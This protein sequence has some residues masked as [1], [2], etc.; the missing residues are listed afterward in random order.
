MSLPG[1]GLN[2]EEESHQ[3]TGSIENHEVPKECEWRFEVAFGSYVQV[4]LVTGTAEIFGTELCPGQSYT[5]TGTKAAIFTWEGCTIQVS[6][7]ALQSD[8]I[9]EETPMVEYA[10]VHFALEALRDAAAQAGRD[11]P[12]VLL[13][14]PDNAGKT[15]LTK[16]LTGYA[17]RVGRQPIVVNVDPNE[18][19][20]SIPGTLSSAAFK[21]LIDV[22]EG[23]GSSP[24]SGPSANPVKLPLVYSYPLPSPSIQD[25]AHYRPVISKLALSVIGR[26]YED[27]A[28]RPSGLIVDTPSSLS[29]PSASTFSTLSHII[30]E[31]RISVLLILGSE[32]LSSDL[33]KRFHN[34]PTSATSPGETISVLKL[35]KS[36]GCVDRDDTFMKPLRAAQLRTYFYGN[37]KLSAGI[38]LSPHQLTIP[39]SNLAVYRLLAAAAH[40][41]S[42]AGDASG[43]TDNMFLPGG[44]D[45]LDDTDAADDY[46]PNGDFKPIATTANYHHGNQQAGISSSSTTKIYERMTRPTPAMQNCVLSVMNVEPEGATEEDIRDASV[47]GFLYVVEVDV[48]RGLV[49]VLS[50]VAGRVPERPLVW[51]GW[52]EEVVGMV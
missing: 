26:L 37:P 43:A 21:T 46:H 47:M 30:S 45:P 32:R 44:M 3:D 5:F 20:L 50:P 38:A 18:G 40:D 28:S 12:R 13:L 16:L 17:T 8:Y 1:L 51:G 42:G 2:V 14:G 15:S 41:T 19:F 4:K 9:A 35:S 29:T 7:D 33:T 49:N 6:G 25:G 36:G 23:W 39:F 24:I 10:N 48:E 31:F 52:P 11:G 34:Q 22:E 27:P